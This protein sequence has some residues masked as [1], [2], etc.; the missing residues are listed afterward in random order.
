MAKCPKCGRM[1][2]EFDPVRWE[3]RCLWLDCR[4]WEPKVAD[5]LALGRAIREAVNGRNV[6]EFDE[7]ASRAVHDFLGVEK[8]KEMGPGAVA[9]MVEGIRWGIERCD[10]KP[11]QQTCVGCDALP[12]NAVDDAGV[13][14]LQAA[15]RAAGEEVT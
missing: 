15:L 7:R 10:A 2:Y 5:E 4:H 3:W 14:P 9:T 13:C 6:M 12:E 1:H 8:G 11:D